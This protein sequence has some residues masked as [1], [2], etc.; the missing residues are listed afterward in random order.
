MSFSINQEYLIHCVLSNKIEV[1]KGTNL[2]EMDI[3]QLQ[4]LLS[5]NGINTSKK[6]F[7][8]AEN[9]GF[10]KSGDYQQNLG[11]HYYNL[12]RIA[13]QNVQEYEASNSDRTS[14][15]YKQLNF[16]KDMYE[17]LCTAYLEGKIDR[18]LTREEAVEYT[19]KEIEDFK[20]K[21]PY[22]K[23]WNEANQKFIEIEKTMSPESEAYKKAYKDMRYY[24]HLVMN[25]SEGDEIIAKKENIS[26]ADPQIKNGYASIDMEDQNVAFFKSKNIVDI[27]D[28]KFTLSTGGNMN[29]SH[30][31]GRYKENVFDGIN[32]A[33]A[34]ANIRMSTN[35]AGNDISATVEERFAPDF[36][37]GNLS[38]Y[39]SV[40][41]MAMRNISRFNINTSYSMTDIPKD[42]MLLNYISVGADYQV[43]NNLSLS[44]SITHSIERN[45]NRY[46][47]GANY[48]SSDNRFKITGQLAYDTSEKSFTALIKGIFKL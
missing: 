28:G 17:T 30:M 38:S 23:L 7:D 10:Q 24:E 32:E 12:T 19:K 15:K 46:E 48:R 34:T 25:W 1:P 16:D 21:C 13:I 31:E 4:E 11:L 43:N 35:L 33:S 36:E 9:M 3:D 6:S 14:D 45:S 44:G 26:Y 2:Y 8:I 39:T 20:E 42:N 29:L 40:R 47:A 18:L 37:N 22:W 5:K 41:L 27:N